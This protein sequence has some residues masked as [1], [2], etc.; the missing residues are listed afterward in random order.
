R[1]ARSPAV[2]TEVG[3]VSAG[4]G[5][6][7]E[8][9]GSRRASPS[10]PSS[11]PSSTSPS[12]R[13]SSSHRA[14]GSG[15]PSPR[16]HGSASVST[17]SFSH[18]LTTGPPFVHEPLQGQVHRIRGPGAGGGPYRGAAASWWAAT[19]TRTP[20]FAVFLAVSGQ[21]DLPAD[22]HDE[23]PGDAHVV[24]ACAELDGVGW[25]G[26]PEEHLSFLKDAGSPSHQAA[27]RFRG[28]RVREQR[29]G[30]S[31]K[32]TLRNGRHR[33]PM[34]MSGQFPMAADIP[35]Q[36]FLER[37]SEPAGVVSPFFHHRR[38]RRRQTGT[39]V[40]EPA[41]RSCAAPRTDDAAGPARPPG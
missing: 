38:G 40:W 20:L 21:Q 25:T 19:G 5:G 17:S 11:Q 6:S 34:A 32:L 39:P 27:D 31:R 28:G 7:S 22:G 13:S 10:A 18:G 35:G 4:G 3:D 24:T 26:V 16:A 29:G 36:R 2:V 9:R 15:S 14:S 12:P 30:Q 8:R 41:T 1:S 33:D 37:P 23:V